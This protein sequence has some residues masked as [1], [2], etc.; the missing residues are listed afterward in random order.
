MSPPPAVAPATAFPQLQPSPVLRHPRKIRERGSE[1]NPCRRCSGWTLSNPRAALQ[2]PRRTSHRDE[3]EPKRK[4]DMKHR[5]CWHP[6]HSRRLFSCAVHAANPRRPR[7][8]C[9]RLARPSRSSSHWVFRASRSRRHSRR[10]SHRLLDAGPR[11]GLPCT[12]VRIPSGVDSHTP[13]FHGLW[14]TVPTA[15]PAVLHFGENG[16]ADWAAE[17]ALESGGF[18]GAFQSA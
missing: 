17:F 4:E 10:R 2:E 11:G 18:A 9:C 3:R 12:P 7:N 14:F 6:K 5:W 8:R 1:D 15:L 13:V 16:R